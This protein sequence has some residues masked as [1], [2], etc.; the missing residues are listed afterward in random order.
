MNIIYFLQEMYL[1]GLHMREG[2][3]GDNPYFRRIK[4]HKEFLML[5]SLPGVRNKGALE[6]TTRL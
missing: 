3:Q 4:A 1:L 6:G 2:D 5:S